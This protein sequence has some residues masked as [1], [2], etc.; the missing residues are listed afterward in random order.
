MHQRRF[1]H[2]S[3]LESVMSTPVFRKVKAKGAALRTES[4]P[5]RQK[6][7]I[8]SGLPVWLSE[9]RSFDVYA[10]PWTVITEITEISELLLLPSLG[11]TFCTRRTMPA[12]NHA[13]FPF[14]RTDSI[15]DDDNY[16]IMITGKHAT[17]Q[18]SLEFDVLLWTRAAR[19]SSE[20]GINH[21]G[22]KE[23]QGL[24]RVGR[25]RGRRLVRRLQRSPVRTGRRRDRFVSLWVG[26]GQGETDTISGFVFC[27]TSVRSGQC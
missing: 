12:S 4:S 9:T 2:V 15:Y 16:V 17:M 18:D 25:A 21:R 8:Y 7:L 22:W 6:L 11:C 14:R 23:R 1:N 26:R 5:L 19:V 10:A 20:N 24:C 3:A 13:L 27:R